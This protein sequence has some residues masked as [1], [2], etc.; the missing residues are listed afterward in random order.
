MPATYEPIT[1]V[2]LESDSATY[3]FNNIPQTFTDLVL[4][5]YPI[6]SA[7]GAT[8]YMRFNSDSGSNYSHSTLVGNNTSAN[9]YRGSN[10]SDGIGIGGMQG[11]GTTNNIIIVDIMNYSNTTTNKTIFDRYGNSSYTVDLTSGMWRSTAAITSI[12]L[13]NNGGHNFN[14]GS[15]FSLYGIKAA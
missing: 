4:I 11:Y 7:T 14:S 2:K 5:S 8:V 15:I 9:S 10:L 6:M 1:Y 12:T 3:T 13:R